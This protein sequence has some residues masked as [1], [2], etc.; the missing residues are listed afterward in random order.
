M[1]GILKR[2][3]ANTF[4]LL[5]I[6][7]LNLKKLNKKHN[8]NYIRIINFHHT[9]EGDAENFEKQIKWFKEHFCNI[10]Y[11]QFDTFIKT[12]EKSGE[13]PGIIFTFDD[14]FVDNYTVA[15]PILEKYGFT[16]FFMVSSELIGKAGYMN[17]EQ[18]KELIKNGHT[19]TS[20]TA[21]HYRMIPNDDVNMLDYQITV[22]KMRIEAM[23]ESPVHIFTWVGGEE[24]FYT[25]KAQDLIKKAGYSYGFMTN[26]APVLKGADP[27]LIQRTNVEAD[28][29]ISRVK[30]SVCGFMDK[31]YK[32]KRERIE[33]LMK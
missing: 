6:S 1:N 3:L 10:T 26:S 18:L 31:K 14:G 13:R 8:N 33:A 30:L 21:T 27:F 22:S 12:G 19:V 11:T 4:D 24:D 15:K 9:R 29:N 20:H 16:A 23:I 32:A 17:I 7:D 2:V 5:Q 28:W 25:K